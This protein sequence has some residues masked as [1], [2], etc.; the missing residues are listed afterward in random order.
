MIDN[1]AAAGPS[2]EARIVI[3]PN[4]SLSAH[5]VIGVAAGY[6][7]VV[8]L[9]SALSWLQGNAF[10]P[11]F[12]LLN[13]GVFATCL[14]VVW[15]RC[16]RAE[17]IAVGSEHVRV[18]RLPE[19]VDTFD[20]HPAWVRLDSSSGRVVMCSAGRRIEVGSWLGEGERLALAR[21]L[22]AALLDARSRLHRGRTF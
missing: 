1:F 8:T 12:A 22:D 15:R 10:A 2:G 4:R 17:V 20:A 18:R 6:A 7:V 3:R 21:E 13:A 14:T 16:S 5:Q 11:L 9:I 19:L